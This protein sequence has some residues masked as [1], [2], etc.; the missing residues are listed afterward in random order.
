MSVDSEAISLEEGD[1][2]MV[3]HPRDGEIFRVHKS[4]NNETDGIVYLTTKDDSKVRTSLSFASL[5]HST[6]EV[7]TVSFTST[8]SIDDTFFAWHG[9][10]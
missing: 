3:G 8:T 6:Y 1:W 5:K 4:P 2:I 7:Q 9:M 10:A